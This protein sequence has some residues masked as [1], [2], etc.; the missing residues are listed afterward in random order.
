MNHYETLGVQSNATLEEIRRAYLAKRSQLRPER[1]V[2]APEHVLESVERAN[3]V[4]DEAWRVLSEPPR[5][6]RYDA[7]LDAGDHLG[8]DTRRSRAEHIWAMERE[9]GWPLSP[10]LGLEPPTPLP[11][12]YG[13]GLGAANGAE[14]PDGDGR[15]GLQRRSY[16]TVEGGASPIVAALETLAVWL[17]PRRRPSTNV[18]VPDVCGLRASEAYYAVAKSDLHINFVRLTED[19]SG[20]DGTVV[21]QYPPAGT[22]VR[23]GA[24]LNVQVV[25]PTEP[26]P[27]TL[28]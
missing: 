23:R 6:A 24:T 27:I 19:P 21:D 17:A 5:R 26:E 1:F 2:G 11:R 28:R 20:G 22:S 25:H 16:P 13:G 7:A 14:R 12:A 18:S 3:G 10:V 15:L 4:I 8:G 9:L